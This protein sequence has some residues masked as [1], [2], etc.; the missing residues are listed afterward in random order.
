MIQAT[1]S[2]RLSSTVQRKVN[3]AQ[4]FVVACQS[5]GKISFTLSELTEES[6]LSPIA[7]AAQLKRLSQVVRVSPRADFF[8]I[9]S[10]E[11][12]AMGAPPASWWLHEYFQQQKNPY[13]LALLS[14][15]AE[16]GSSHQVVQVV[17]VMT[18]KPMRELKIG[19]IRVQFFVKKHAEKSP[20][21]RLPNAFSPLNVSTPEVTAL[22][23]IRYAYRIGGIGRATQ[24]ISGLVSQFSK[25]GLRQALQ[26]EVETST[27]QRL[28]FILEILAQLELS[29]IVEEFLPKKLNRVMLEHHKIAATET[30]LPLSAKWSVVINA[31]IT[32]LS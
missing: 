10:P 11:Q 9:L 24:A 2:S 13:Y 4:R 26:T 27:I 32:E 18:D 12:L 16:Y 8:L 23:L 21:T 29:K 22:D 20:T 14:A 6:G 30:T 19:R 1:L 7:A 3:A 28:G 17:Q 31:D 25:K 15:A 5:V